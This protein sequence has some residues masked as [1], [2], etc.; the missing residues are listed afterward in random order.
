MSNPLDADVYTEH[1]T[2][3]TVAKYAPSGFYIAS[4]DA[5]GKIRIWDT[6]NAEHI[7]KI[8]LPVLAGPVTDLAWTEDSKRIVAVG[9]GRE[10]F[11]AAFMFDSGSTVGEISG[12]SKTIN[13][14][15][16]KPNRP[17]RAATGG[18]DNLV[19]FFP[20]PPFKFDHSGKDHTRFVNC[21]RYAP[22]GSVFV[23]AGSDKRVY[24]YD[25]KTGE[26]KAVFDD[27]KN[28]GH[29]AGIYSASFSAD[30][31]KLLTASADKVHQFVFVHSFLLFCFQ[32]EL[33]ECYSFVFIDVS[34]AFVNI[35]VDC[36][37]L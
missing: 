33:C 32:F 16:V 22:D 13:S 10:V 9:D 26:K 27:E 21:V 14:C 18:L 5:S 19:N 34:F 3:C 12:H 30:S 20:G 31:S 24:V 35:I 37:C 4:G 17:Y 1:T 6:I 7:L 36:S 28:G 15:D 2:D 29:T 8:E 25:G 11:G 23:S